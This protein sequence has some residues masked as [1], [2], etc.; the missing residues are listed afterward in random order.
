M[1]G[2]SFKSAV[3]Q[4]AP[5]LAGRFALY[6]MAAALGPPRHNLRDL[7]LGATRQ[8]GQ[9]KV[10]QEDM[11]HEGCSASSLSRFLKTLLE[12]SNPAVWAEADLHRHRQTFTVSVRDTHPDRLRPN[13]PPGPLNQRE[14]VGM[15]ELDWNDVPSTDL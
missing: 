1:T 14:A 11:S 4:H 6:F 13:L 3:L 5:P 12:M 2:V 8:Q 9:A 15:A 10:G 7:R